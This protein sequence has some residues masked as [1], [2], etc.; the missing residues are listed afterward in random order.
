[1]QALRT[2]VNSTGASWFYRDGFIQRNNNNAPSA[3]ITGID[4]F[5]FLAMYSTDMQLNT[6][7]Q[8][9]SFR[10]PKHGHVYIP[11]NTYQLQGAHNF[12]YLQSALTCRFSCQEGHKDFTI[13]KGKQSVFTVLDSLV[14]AANSLK[15]NSITY[16][17]NDKGIATVTYNVTDWMVTHV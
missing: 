7:W 14:A 8:A 3:Y 9:F 12:L 4:H 5:L 2:I 15:A 17:K 13:P 1:M 6:K 10:I 16:T 11:A